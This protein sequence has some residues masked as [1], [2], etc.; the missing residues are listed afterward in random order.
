MLSKNKIVELNNQ[1]LQLGAPKEK[2]DIGYNKPD[3]ALMYNLAYIP[4]EFLKDE[5]AAVMLNI[6]SRYS[7]TQLG[8]YKNELAET[9]DFYKNSLVLEGNENFLSYIGDRDV[10]F[11]K[12]AN[13][14]YIPKELRKTH[15]NTISVLGY[16][17]KGLL[18]DFED[19]NTAHKFKNQ[20]EGVYYT[21]RA[22]GWK[23][24]VPYEK[25]EDF[26]ALM[27]NAKKKGIDGY[28]PNE[29]LEKILE[30]I[31]AFQQSIAE[32][33]ENKE[34]EKDLKDKTISLIK[35]DTEEMKLTVYFKK[36]SQ[37]MNNFKS[38]NSDK[39]RNVKINGSWYT[40]LNYDIVNEWLEKAEQAGLIV[41]DELKEI[42]ID[43]AIMQSQQEKLEKHLNHNELVDLNTISLPFEP[44][45]FQIEDAK[46]LLER[47]KML[48]GHDM[49]CGKTFI[50]G[51]VGMS[52]EG[53]KLV[54]CPETLRLNWKK[55]MENLGLE[56]NILYSKDEFS[57]SENKNAFTI[58]GYQTASKFREQL[59]NEN[60]PCVFVD[61]VHNCK[62][63]NSHGEPN[64][65]R[66]SSVIDIA[67]NS[68]YTYVLSGTPI[69]TRNKDIYNV[70]RMLDVE[71]INFNKKYAFFNFGTK[72]CGAVNN[73]YGWSFDGNTESDELHELI[74]KYMVRRTKKEVLPNLTKQRICIPLEIHSREY[75][76]IEKRIINLDDRDTYMGLAM[77]GRRILS[78][79]KVQAAVEFAG[80][81]LKEDKSV[82]IVSNFDDTL[83]TLK[84]QFGDDC[85][86]IKGGMSDAAKQK[87]IDDFQSGTCKVC[88]LNIVAGGVGITLTK[89]HDMIICDYDW[90]PANMVQVED[91]ICRAG[92]TEQCNIHYLYG[93]GCM[94]DEI[95]VDMITDKSRNIDRVIDGADN[96]M[97][98]TSVKETS[99]KSYIDILKERAEAKRE[100]QGIPSKPARKS[101]PKP[102]ANKNNFE[103]ER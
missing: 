46:R 23:L 82:V 61:E 77:T 9:F 62:A 37:E 41:S 11:I 28:K 15:Y 92:Q 3:Y 44:Y 2:D 42:D 36:Y 20:N 7:N 26:I 91:R 84:E 16:N 79:N 6:L 102:K 83:T 27:Q 40:V 1:M 12:G 30:D 35:N 14:K 25:L 93:N 45:D 103:M 31:P 86:V 90:T 51:L 72:Y 5:Y 24:F 80:G 96:S 60:F 32:K 22:D 74:S 18:L 52:I 63:L 55:E 10:S 75:D 95:F 19:I 99:S 53:K 66:A 49:G 97:D 39:I 48:I 50:S 94:L 89:A 76:S 38:E 17:Q 101:K 81:L 67:K 78:E 64:S 8:S 47:D 85:C 65:Q 34:Q 98:L 21:Q 73:G 4:A 56:A 88:A 71:E 43:K 54:I 57:I 33:S 58:V 100:E 68:K 29:Q 70:L 59:I 13:A 69:P 87:A